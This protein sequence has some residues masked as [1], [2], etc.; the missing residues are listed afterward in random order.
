[1]PLSALDR[2]QFPVVVLQ[3]NGVIKKLLAIKRSNNEGC[4]FCPIWNYQCNSRYCM[5]F[6]NPGIGAV[7]S[8]SIIG[9]GVIYFVSQKDD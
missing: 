3:T 4:N 6:F 9:S 2:S 5:C 1:M 7:V 8:I